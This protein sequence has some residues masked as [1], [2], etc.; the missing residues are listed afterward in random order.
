MAGENENVQWVIDPL[1]GTTNFVKRLPHFAVS[2]A[3]R[4]NGRTTVG[5]VYDPIRNELFTAVRG[6]G[7]KLNEF[8][9]RVETERRDLNGTVLA[10][11]FS[12][13]SG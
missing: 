2:I 3:V 6:E 7:A 5:V 8:R 12:F 4:E 9:L 10:T 13:Q 11:G 1:D